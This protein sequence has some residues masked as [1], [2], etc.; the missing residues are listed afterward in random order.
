MIVT[1]E[2]NRHLFCGGTPLPGVD[3]VV[4]RRPL[5]YDPTPGRL[6]TLDP[7]EGKLESPQ[8]LHKYAYCHGD[9]VN[10][11]D[12]SGQLIGALGGLVGLMVGAF[13]SVNAEARYNSA[14]ASGGL[15]IIARIGLLSAKFVAPG[16]GVVGGYGLAGWQA[17][18]AFE[19]SA[20]WK[21]PGNLPGR[22]DN[23]P[24]ANWVSSIETIL[25]AYVD[26][27]P[28]LTPQQVADGHR[29]AERI[30]SGYVQAVQQRA[31][32]VFKIE[33]ASY[34][35]F[36]KGGGIANWPGNVVSSFTSGDRNCEQW[37]MAIYNAMRTTGVTGGWKLHGR[38]GTLMAGDFSLGVLF[39][40]NFVSLTF[41]PNNTG[42]SPAF[43]LD[44]WSRARPD[45]Y[46][47]SKFNMLWPI[48]SSQVEWEPIGD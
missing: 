3:A 35:M 37:A 23:V 27:Q 22:D 11:T 29:A 16:I 41:D 40:H 45:I 10:N 36:G 17:T 43:I 32:T 9:P 12:P 47:F 24:V 26:A 15:S 31:I 13:I 48:E 5:Y 28:G 25:K 6:T 2:R 30:A 1:C 46:E 4:C 7:F 34:V 38:F 33:D 20:L 44:P 19:P 39:K 14:V 42:E 18:N 21:G 8:S